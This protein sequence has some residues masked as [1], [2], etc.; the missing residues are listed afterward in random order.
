MSGLYQRNISDL[1]K[2]IISNRAE[3]IIL[4]I[5][6]RIINHFGKGRQVDKR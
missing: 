5:L 1:I 2:S 4:R 6:K 3:R